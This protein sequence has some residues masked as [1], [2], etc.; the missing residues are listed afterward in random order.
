MSTEFDKRRDEANK[1]SV[2]GVEK[3]RKDQRDK[4]W[5]SGLETAQMAQRQKWAKFMDDLRNKHKLKN[6]REGGPETYWQEVD[7]LADSM[8]NSEQNAF[9]DWRSNM[10][11]LLNML[12]KLNKAINIS[13]DQVGGELVDYVKTKTKNVPYIGAIFHPNERIYQSIKAA[14]MHKLIKG[15]G[16]IA[17]PVLDHKV[18]FKDGKVHI[19]DLTRADTG[20]SLGD[21]KT[22][23]GRL[24]KE[25][26]EANKAFKVFVDLWLEEN[27]YEPILNPP[28][29]PRGTPV[30]YKNKTT[31]ALLD[32]DVFN[33]LN[34]DPNTSF[35]SFLKANAKLKYGEQ[36]EPEQNS[37][38]TPT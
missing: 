11:S 9:N 2:E 23:D 17:S 26:N 29:T 18:T 38:P 30:A 33:D 32:E 15:V 36:Q 19:A 31:G 27:G 8:I 3:L 4:D 6:R 21:K 37:T 12:T 20:A 1:S 14:I 22:A 25:Q 34:N 13:V 24:V 7:Q 16:D 35:S 10:M 5:Q 28:G